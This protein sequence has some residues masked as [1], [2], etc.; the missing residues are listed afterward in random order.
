MRKA[1]EQTSDPSKNHRVSGG[2]G[3]SDA[4]AQPAGGQDGY[5]TPDG[6]GDGESVGVPV[7]KIRS[8]LKHD[9]GNGRCRIIRKFPA[10]L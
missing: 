3:G 7:R 9:G 4:F 10:I 1:R 6:S 8:N 2:S 5:D